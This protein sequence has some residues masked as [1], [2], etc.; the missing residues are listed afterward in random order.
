MLEDCAIV[1]LDQWN[2]EVECDDLRRG[3]PRC[4]L[5]QVVHEEPTLNQRNWPLRILVWRA[6]NLR[7]F[8]RTSPTRSCRCHLWVQ[9]VKVVLVPLVS[10]A[11]GGLNALVNR[12]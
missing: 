12:A 9:L 10:L 7:F 8:F 5:D 6:S 3:L 11:H 1:L 4:D 2:P